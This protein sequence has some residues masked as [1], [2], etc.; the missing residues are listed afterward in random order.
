MKAT[1]SEVEDAVYDKFE[2]MMDEY[3]YD[4]DNIEGVYLHGSRLRGT[5]Q[6]RQLQDFVIS[7][8]GARN[9]NLW[10]SAY[11]NLA[12]TYF[13][14]YG[15]RIDF[16]EKIRS[17]ATAEI[18]GNL[19]NDQEFLNRLAKSK[20]NVF[21]KLYARINE[22]IARVTGSEKAFLNAVKAKMEIAWNEAQQSNSAVGQ[23][24]L[25]YSKNNEEAFENIK[26]KTNQEILKELNSTID[27]I[28]QGKM[29]RGNQ[30][31]LK[32]VPSV[33][34]KIGVKNNPLLSSPNTLRNSIL[35]SEEA[36]KLGYPTGK[37]DNYHALGKTGFME[38]IHDLSSPVLIIKENNN[39]IIVFTEQFD[40]KNRQV[41]VPIEI[42]TQS[43][44]NLLR[45]ESNVIKSLH[46]R[47]SMSNY[48]NKLLANNSSVVYKDTKKIQSLIDSRKVQYP[49]SIS[50]VSTKNDTI[51]LPKSQNM[52]SNTNNTQNKK[53][54]S[55][56]LVREIQGMKATKSEVEDA[57]Y[58]KFEQ[59][60]DE[61]GYD[62]DNI[63]G[64]Y[65]HGSRLRGT[66][67]TDSDLDAVVF[68]IGNE[69]ED[70]IF[71]TI[72][73][74]NKVY[75]IDLYGDINNI[76]FWN[77]SNNKLYSDTALRKQFYKYCEESNIPKKG[78]MI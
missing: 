51:K 37:N 71:N 53:S 61:Y 36:T 78:H 45:V 42:N 41:I 48:I 12:S 2:Q 57:V 15:N 60:M 47:S 6:M 29:P 22:L 8:F 58:D 1:K 24:S 56:P 30:V 77:Y 10:Q 5:A 76:T 7:Y 43:E 59:M 25:A 13:P 73:N 32:N 66:A 68:Y 35:S 54:Y 67:K 44:Y 46:G 70:D 33:L 39:K 17:E 31:I 9:E 72:N 23:E 26:N 3:G 20:P 65:L 74:E 38:V 14:V 11:S 69:N 19:I 63:E 28:Y 16:N 75:L 49:E 4:V 34:R 21:L 27:N 55:L 52:A 62:V 40:Y 64:V 50:S 18:L